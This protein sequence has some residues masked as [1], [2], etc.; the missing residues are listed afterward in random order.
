MNYISIPYRKLEKYCSINE[1]IKRD[2]GFIPYRKYRNSGRRRSS[3]RERFVSI[4]YRKYR[5]QSREHVIHRAAELFP[6]LIGSIEIG[7]TNFFFLHT[8][9]VS[10]PYRK[11]RNILMQGMFLLSYPVSIPYRKYRNEASFMMQWSQKMFPSLIG[12]IEIIDRA[13]KQRALTGFHPL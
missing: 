9:P 6:S 10:I 5:N 12:S 8:I 2:R 4:P 13:A 1:E 3:Y 7:S 11:Y